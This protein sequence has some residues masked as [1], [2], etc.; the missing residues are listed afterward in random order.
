MRRN[1]LRM[2]AAMPSAPSR[3]VLDSA[4]KIAA[5]SVLASEHTYSDACSKC[6]H[7]HRTSRDNGTRRCRR[8][9]IRLHRSQFHAG[10]WAVAGFG[11]NQRS[12]PTCCLH[13]SRLLPTRLY[14][15]AGRINLL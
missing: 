10:H 13:Q 8:S 5:L 2:P 3:V 4:G 15:P 6:G 11:R 14:L 1:G 12:C 7:Q 9:S